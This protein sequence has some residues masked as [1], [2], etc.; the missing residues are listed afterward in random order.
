MVHGIHLWLRI[1]ARD[2]T[3]V[4]LKTSYDHHFKNR[5]NA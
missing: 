1:F 3:G 4:N 2:E 5:I